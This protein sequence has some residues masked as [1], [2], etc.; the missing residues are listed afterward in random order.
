[1]ADLPNPLAGLPMDPKTGQPSGEQIYDMLMAKIDP[2]LLSASLPTLEEKYK[3]ETPEQ[4]KARGERY[5]LAFEQYDAAY[6]EYM[7][8]IAQGVHSFQHS[9]MASVESDDKAREQADLQSL[10]SAISSL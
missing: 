2:E 10:D 6:Q 8:G 4:K 7:R 9:A 3:N 1:M 5:K